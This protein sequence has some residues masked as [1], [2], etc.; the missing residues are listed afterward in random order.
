MCAWQSHAPAVGASRG[1]R[2]WKSG[3]A[4]RGASG[5]KGRDSRGGSCNIAKNSRAGVPGAFTIR[6]G[7]GIGGNSLGRF[8]VASFLSTLGQSAG[9]LP[10]QMHLA[11]EL[12][13]A[14]PVP[15][16]FKAR[17]GRYLGVNGAWEE[18]F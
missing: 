14:L 6:A 4:Q 10:G 9:D 5:L 7:L 11:Q 13:E 12:I 15:V 2:G 17:D 1:R 3:G 16:F 18:F 8:D